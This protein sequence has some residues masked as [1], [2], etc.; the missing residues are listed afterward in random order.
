MKLPFWVGVRDDQRKLALSERIWIGVY[1]VFIFVLL[2]DR[3]RA[4][5]G[6]LAR[7]GPWLREIRIS[8]CRTYNVGLL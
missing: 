5:H 4:L 1:Q 3:R 6:C 2:G 7:S 8:I